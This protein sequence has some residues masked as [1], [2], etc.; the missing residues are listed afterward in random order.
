MKII[1]AGSRS[2][3][4]LDVVKRAVIESGFL[5][6]ITEV[7][8]GCADGVDKLGY[9]WARWHDVPQIHVS[10][11]PAWK[12]QSEWAHS[13]VKGAERVYVCPPEYLGRRAGFFR[14]KKMA[15]Y[16][17]KLIAVWDG[18]SQGT[19]DMICQMRLAGK[20]W[21]VYRTDVKQ[22]RLFEAA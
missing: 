16:A 20:P 4:D 7:V 6:S 9:E 19:A 15:E 3:T 12:K 13:V 21:F 5:P 1:I 11:W 18:R 8:C 17:D 14:N 22:G 10:F 2:I